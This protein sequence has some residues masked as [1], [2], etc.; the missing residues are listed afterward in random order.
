MVPLTFD[1]GLFLDVLWRVGLAYLL[2]LPI[3]LE[4]ERQTRVHVGLRTLPIVAVAACGSVLLFAM[5]AEAS[6]DSQARVVQGLLAGVG[7]IG[8]GVI[9]RQ[10]T[11]VRGLVTAATIWNTAAI[12]AAVGLGRLELAVALALLNILTLL[13]VTPLERLWDKKGQKRD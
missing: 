13:I 8:A 9:M 2:A 6:P 7:F 1:F 4:R 11:S 10:G 5:A 3:G 12:G